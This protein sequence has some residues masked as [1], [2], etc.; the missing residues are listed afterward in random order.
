MERGNVVRLIERVRA[1]LDAPPRDAP[2]V[3]PAERYR[4]AAW[5]DRERAALFGAPRLVAASTSLAAGACVPVDLPDVSL[6]LTRGTDGVVRGFRNACRHRGTRL[7]DAPCTAKAMV[8]P[9]H[10]WTYDLAGRLLHLPH[11]DAF[12]GIDPATRGLAPLPVVERHGLVWLGAR[13]AAD[14]DRHLGDVGADLAALA[15]ERHIVWKR[16]RAR[17]R[18]NWKL[19]VEAFL[20]G[21]HLRVLHRD[22]VYRFFL[23]AAS[24][25]EPCGDHLR[26]VTARRALR[27]APADLA[28]LD[29]A[30]LR[31]LATPSL[32]VF[33]A[34]TIV[35]HPDFTSIMTV[36]P[37]A[38]DLTDWD[39]LMFVPADRAGDAEHWDRSWALIEEGVFQAEDLW[40]CEQAQRSIATGDVDE[41]LFGAHESAVRWFHDAIDRVCSEP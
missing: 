21:Y 32:L 19:V 39:H 34:T 41:L 5:C 33:P 25:A 8:C 14:L 7:V 40:V 1:A 27:E 16:G 35:V 18:C 29:D 15:L 4:A 10:A 28:A 9:Y 12:A 2:F 17:R 6:L 24:A 11:A 31:Q 13:D 30:A 38:A 3:A 22:S 26:A 23:D 36:H 20:D 37:L